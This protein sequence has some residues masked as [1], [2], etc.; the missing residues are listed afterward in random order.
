MTEPTYLA[1]LVTGT[2]RTPTRPDVEAIR[3]ALTAVQP[4]VVIHGAATGVDQLA[5]LWAREV[6]VSRIPLPALWTTRGRRAGPERNGRL[7]DMLGVFRDSGY[8]C[9]V[10]AFPDGDSVGTWNCVDQ[11]RTARFEPVVRVIDTVR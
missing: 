2:R 4:T 3:A 10:L 9:V 7:V 5:D 11:A 6:G 1:V 8:D